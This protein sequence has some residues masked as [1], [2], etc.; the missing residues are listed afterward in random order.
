MYITQNLVPKF[1][2][3]LAILKKK[4]LNMHDSTDHF[5][6][7]SIINALLFAPVTM[8]FAVP[9]F[10]IGSLWISSF[11]TLLTGSLL[12]ALPF[13]LTLIHGHVTTSLGKTHRHLYYEWIERTL[14]LP[15]SPVAPLRMMMTTRFRIGMMIISLVW[16]LLAG[17]FSS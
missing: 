3:P 9:Y 15:Q 17:I 14:R 6:R 5:T 11:T 2:N 13:T 7:I 12:F 4:A 16:L 8:V 10:K 1:R